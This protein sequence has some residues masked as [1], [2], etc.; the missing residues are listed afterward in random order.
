[1]KKWLEPQIM[2]LSTKATRNGGAGIGDDIVTYV[3]ENGNEVTTKSTTITNPS[4][5]S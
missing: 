3:N 2:E 5:I 4:D 1:M